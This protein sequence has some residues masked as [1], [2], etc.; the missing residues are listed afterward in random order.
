MKRSASAAAWPSGC[1]LVGEER[2]VAP[3]P[4]RR[5]RAS[6]SR[7]P[8][9]AA[10]RPGYHLPW[11]KCTKPFGA[12]ALPSAATADPS[13]AARLVGP[14]RRRCSTRRASRSS[15]DT[16]V[17][18]PPIVSRTSCRGEVA[19]RPRG[20][21]RRSPPTARR[22]TAWSRAAIRRCARRTSRWSNSTSHGSTAPVIGRG[23]RRLGRARERDVAFAGEQARRRIEADPAGA[24]QVDLAPG[25][26]IGEVAVGARPGR[27]A[28]SRRASAESG[29]RTRS[30]P[31]G[32]GAGAAARAA[33]S[34][35]GTSPCRA[36]SVSSVV[37]TP[38]SRR[39]T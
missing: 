4:A 26:Q 38:G 12:E 39:M 30:A 24:G 28:P 34:C 10:A 37:W 13:R 3:R 15:A 17:G 32:R 21:A 18:S 25:V 5:R 27:R 31:R 35:R 7:A 11:P 23:A 29:S 2:R 33:T 14:E 16:N 20:R 19:R 8:S 9:A 6:S 1:S 22:C 36:S